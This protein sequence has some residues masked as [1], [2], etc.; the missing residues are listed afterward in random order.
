MEDDQIVTVL[1]TGEESNSNLFSGAEKRM[2]QF[3]ENLTQTPSEVREDDIQQLR[4]AGFS[5]PEILEIVIVGGYFNL[6]N[7]MTDGLG[8]ELE[9]WYEPGGTDA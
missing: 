9:E 2:F 6:M 1:K 3:L 4:D 8:V 5:D 7:R